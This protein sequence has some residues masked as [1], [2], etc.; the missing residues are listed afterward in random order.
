MFIKRTIR[1]YEPYLP[2]RCR[3]VRCR[4]VREIFSV[5]IKE[6]GST[7]APVAII[8]HGRIFHPRIEYHWHQKRL[9]TRVRLSYF[10]SLNGKRDRQAK[11]TDISV[12]FDDYAGEATREQV[13]TRLDL[14]AQKFVIIDG[15]LSVETGE[16]RYC[17]YTMGL[18]CNHSSTVLN[19]D[20]HYNSNISKDRYFRCD[21][22]KEALAA[23]E[24]IALARGDTDSVPSKY[25]S[26]FEISI[27]AA[28]QCQP[29]HEHG[30][31]DPFLNK[32]E[33]I[34]SGVK[35]PFIAGLGLLLASIE[36]G[37]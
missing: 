7:E 14:W 15:K 18:G 30:D 12:P 31:G 24:R 29:Q 9:F 5:E 1:F 2:P 11:P 21:Q 35:E 22:L 34:I 27:S 23:H 26:S 28:V 3:K 16:P 10:L 19:V 33:R 13:Q 36:P 17:I 4:E 37:S 8:E 6:V 25:H 20:N 32:A